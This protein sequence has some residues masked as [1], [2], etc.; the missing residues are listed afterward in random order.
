MTREATQKQWSSGD[1][2][3]TLPL[4]ECSHERVNPTRFTNADEYLK[5]PRSEGPANNRLP[6]MNSLLN[7][8]TGRSPNMA[9][10]RAEAAACRKVLPSSLGDSLVLPSSAAGGLQLLIQGLEVPGRHQARHAL[11]ELLHELQ[12]SHGGCYT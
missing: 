4:H 6:A 7:Y 12:A 10:L 5:A 8:N 1:R 9:R 2:T 11:L 3:T